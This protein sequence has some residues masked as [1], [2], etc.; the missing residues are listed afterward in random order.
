MFDVAIAECEAF[1]TATAEVE[2]VE[3]SQCA[4]RGIAG[5]TAARFRR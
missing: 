3:V 4:Q 1:E 5:E 2:N